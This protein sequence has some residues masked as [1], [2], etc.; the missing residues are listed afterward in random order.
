MLVL[1]VLGWMVLPLRPSPYSHEEPRTK[2]YKGQAA[3]LEQAGIKTVLFQSVSDTA[4][5]KE[6]TSQIDI[7]LN[8][9]DAFD[10]KEAEA[11]I[12]GLAESH[13]S[14]GVETLYLHVGFYFLLPFLFLPGF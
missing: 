8:S 5:L 14:S 1:S 9:A 7:A 10:V 2:F 3:K 4:L 6:Q 11:L 13:K 12:Q